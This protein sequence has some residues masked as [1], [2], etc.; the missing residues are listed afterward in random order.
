MGR[1]NIITIEFHSPMTW[2]YWIRTTTA[3]DTN[4]TYFDPGEKLMMQ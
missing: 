3:W 1:G 2:V 4:Q